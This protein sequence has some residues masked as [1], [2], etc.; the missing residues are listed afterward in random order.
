MKKPHLN[1][2]EIL[3]EVGNLIALVDDDSEIE[4]EV[5]RLLDNAIRLRGLGEVV[6]D[7]A[8]RVFVPLIIAAVRRKV[9]GA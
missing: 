9:E 4:R 2:P 6:S 8:I 7:A 5:I 3:D 1:I